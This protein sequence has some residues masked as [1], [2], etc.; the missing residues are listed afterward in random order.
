MRSPWF[1]PDPCFSPFL[2]YF[3]FKR[4]AGRGALRRGPSGGHSAWKQGLRLWAGR[5]GVLPASPPWPPRL[6]LPESTEDNASAGAG[7]GRPLP[8][9]SPRPAAV[10][11]PLV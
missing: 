3:L 11:R 7:T 5:G 9:P 6:V 10:G 1:K 8:A 4:I 2:E